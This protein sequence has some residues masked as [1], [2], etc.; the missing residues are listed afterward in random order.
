MH[1]MKEHISVNFTGGQ[2]YLQML[3]VICKLISSLNAMEVWIG[4]IFGWL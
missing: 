3:V 1:C 4:S 2:G